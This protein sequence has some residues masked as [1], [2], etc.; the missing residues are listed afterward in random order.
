M[1]QVNIANV[2]DI[3]DKW[4]NGYTEIA[5]ND[6]I[7]LLVSPDKSTVAYGKTLAGT[8]YNYASVAWSVVNS[9]EIQTDQSEKEL[10]SLLH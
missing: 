4:K 8:N 9:D 2:K 7:V 6:D 10:V 1:T 3:M 5:S